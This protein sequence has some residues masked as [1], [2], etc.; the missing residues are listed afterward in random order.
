[1]VDFYC[2]KLR[3]AIE[4]G[5]DSHITKRGRDE[6]RDK[7]LKQIGID[8]IRFSNEKIINEIDEVRNKILSQV[9]GRSG[10]AERD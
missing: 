5:G 1:M 8:T 4:I 6:N 3:L 2:S 7:F 10:E 9:I